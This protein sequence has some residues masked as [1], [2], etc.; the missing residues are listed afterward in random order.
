MIVWVWE[1]S[2]PENRLLGVCDAEGRA[3][4]AVEDSLTGRRA[5]GGIEMAW[6]RFGVF[7]SYERSGSG[8]TAVLDRKSEFAVWTPFRV[9][10]AS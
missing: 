7:I 4:E 1:A 9:R 6:V 3:R 5:S 2:G 10:A 8:E